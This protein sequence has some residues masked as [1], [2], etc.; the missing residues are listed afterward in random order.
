MT[1]LNAQ[2]TR[3]TVRVDKVS[4]FFGEGGSRNRVLFD[5]SIEIEAG[6]LVVMTGPSGSGKTTLL[7]LIGALR[8]VQ[9]GRIEARRQLVRSISPPAGG[10][11]RSANRF[12]AMSS[13]WRRNCGCSLAKRCSMSGAVG[14]PLRNIARF[15]DVRVS[16]E[17]KRSRVRASLRRAATCSAATSWPC[18]SLVRAS[19]PLMPS[20]RPVMDRTCLACIVRFFVF[21]SRVP[22]SA[23][24]SGA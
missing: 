2:E 23:P 21:S 1:D 15:A 11:R 16:P 17:R 14:G 13:G 19:M 6:Q 3:A 5:N 18:R 24:T 8:G 7:T 10:T 20:R 9:S 22:A 4:H 12:C